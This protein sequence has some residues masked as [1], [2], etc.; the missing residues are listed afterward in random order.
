MPKS[1]TRCGWLAS[2]VK[3]LK[4]EQRKTAVAALAFNDTL[5]SLIR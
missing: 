2:S 1:E 5:G 4:A 3:P